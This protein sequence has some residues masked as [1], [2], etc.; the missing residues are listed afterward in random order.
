MGLFDK[1]TGK[2]DIALTPKAALA[3]AA[4]P[5]ISADGSVED[6]E[7]ATLKRIVRGDGNAFNQAF[8]VYK[9]RPIQECIGLVGAALNPQQ[10]VAALANLLDIAMADGILAGAEQELLTAYVER[11]QV[12]EEIIKDLVDV[13]AVKNDFSIFDG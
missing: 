2:K 3:L 11:F 6:E 1:L 9:D 7:L 13:I 4:M 10:R 12:N 8:L 5:M